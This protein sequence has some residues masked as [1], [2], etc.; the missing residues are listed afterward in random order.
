M[1][2]EVSWTTK[3]G[4]LFFFGWSLS[5]HDVLWRLPL[6]INL[7]LCTVSA[8]QEAYLLTLVVSHQHVGH[9]RSNDG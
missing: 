3:S 4:W 6:T 8:T 5:E 1:D 2:S 7:A 9:I